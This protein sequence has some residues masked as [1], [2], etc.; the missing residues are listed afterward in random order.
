TFD[1]DYFADRG[2][3]KLALGTP[4]AQAALKMIARMRLKDQTAFNASGIAK[5]GGQEFLNGNIGCVGPIG[6]WMV[7]T[8]KSITKFKWDVVPVPHE[9]KRAS[10]LFYVGWTMSSKSKTPDESFKLIRFLCGRDGQVQQGR[11][12]LAIPALK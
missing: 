2:F 9:A 3:K 1:A 4:Q 6:R 10:Q 11:A 8:Y 7:P 12:G 5:D